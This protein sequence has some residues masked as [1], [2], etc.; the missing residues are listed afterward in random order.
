MR[1]IFSLVLVALTV[2]ILGCSNNASQE[3]SSVVYQGKAIEG[4]SDV[5]WKFKTEPKTNLSQLLVTPEYTYFGTDKALY[6]IDTKTGKE[7][8]SHPINGLPSVPALVGNTLIYNDIG[9]IRAVE[10]DSGVGIWKYDYNENVA[11]EIME[12]STLASSSRA[13]I[14]KNMSDG[15]T[16]INAIDI[17]SGKV[18]WEY[19]ETIP[20]NG[21][22]LVA[23]KLYFSVQ[24]V[25]HIVGEND[26]KLIDTIP[27]D[28]MISN[29][30]VIDDQ[31]FAADLGGSITAY[32][33]SSKERIWQYNNE[34]LAFPTSPILTVLQNRVVI[35][36]VKSGQMIG[37]DSKTG[38]ESWNTRIGDEKYLLAIP[39]VITQ[40]SV[41]SDTLYVGTWD[42]EHDMAKGFPAYSN[43]IAIDSNTGTE[44]WRQR[45]DD[46]IMHSPAFING[47][48]IITNMYES[49]TAYNEG[50]APKQPTTSSESSVEPSSKPD[51]QSMSEIETDAILEEEIQLIDFEGDWST[52]D[53]NEMEITLEFTDS[54]NGIITYHTSG[55]DVPT[56]FQYVHFDYNTLMAKIGPEEEPTVLVLYEKGKLGYRDNQNDYTLEK[57]DVTNDVDDWAQL[58]RD[59]FEGKWC[60]SSQTYCFEL[61]LTD[62]VEGTLDYYQEREPSQESFRITYMDMYDI[63]IDIENSGQVFLSLSKDKETMTYETDSFTEM[64]TRQK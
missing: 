46:Y 37:L 59:G 8:W 20:Y 1:R 6:A 49:I 10:A 43:L 44:L 27:H 3:G 25:I 14:V 58:I 32:D 47:Q 18:S 40:P 63:T 50:K 53:S 35:S 34:D 48:T 5:A 33:L 26:G 17:K 22:V 45:V 61:K 12:K 30:K 7:K 9:G 15:R 51:H 57:A 29:L 24:G 2:S 52:A 11:A 21:I 4:I 42:G 39:W 64:M 16:S 36:D 62:V 55:S 38:N 28:A 23:D 31:L 56:P 54:E 19:G 41:L 13:F 60:D